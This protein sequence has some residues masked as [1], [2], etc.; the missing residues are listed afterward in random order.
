M[1]DVTTLPTMSPADFA[2]SF[3]YGWKPGSPAAQY[4]VALA[5]LLADA[6]PRFPQMADQDDY[7]LTLADASKHYYHVSATPHT[8]TI[9]ANAS[10][11]F[12]VGTEI[13]IVNENGAGALSLAITTDTLRWGSSTGTRTIAAN[14]SATLLKVAA[15]VWRLTGDG[16]T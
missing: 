14:G 5:D 15:T 12:P 2:A 7:T 1:T 4:K 10:V 9:P 11:A 8:L 13:K 6:G 16:I 3:A